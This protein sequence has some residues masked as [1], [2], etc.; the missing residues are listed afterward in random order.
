MRYD[1][2]PAR[3]PTRF[4]WAAG[5]N[6]LH[7]GPA[8][9]GWAATLISASGAT[10]SPELGWLTPILAVGTWAA[11]SGEKPEA[12]GR[13]VRLTA[14]AVECFHKASLIHDDIEDGDR[15]RY[16]QPTLH[17]EYGVPF[18]LNAGDF[19]MQVPL[20]DNQCGGRIELPGKPGL[21]NLLM[22]PTDGSRQ[23]LGRQEQAEK[24]QSGHIGP[25]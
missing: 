11:L 22:H 1:D 24:D 13:D 6:P 10:V 2:H 5:T 16:D 4:H 15:Q 23:E 17:A 8:L 14:T 18:A 12:A 19:L 7:W 20:L 9:I 3:R 25:D 21:L